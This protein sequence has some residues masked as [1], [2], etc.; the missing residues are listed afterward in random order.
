[1]N[2]FLRDVHHYL[3]DVEF[4]PPGRTPVRIQ[5]TIRERFGTVLRTPAITQPH[6]VVSHSMARLF[7]NGNGSSQA[8]PPRLSRKNQIHARRRR[9]DGRDRIH[10]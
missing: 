7:C 3:F 1:M 8:R 10:R 6:I 2:A 9:V 4:A 5:R